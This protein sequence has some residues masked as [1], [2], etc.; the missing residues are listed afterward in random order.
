MDLDLQ[1]I[2]K[3]RVPLLLISIQSCLVI[4][5][6]LVILNFNFFKEGPKKVE[7]FD[8]ERHEFVSVFTQR[9]KLYLYSALLRYINKGSG[10]IDR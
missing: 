9:S 6:H 2:G 8:S 1:R 10:E 4:W 5:N 7:F 3:M